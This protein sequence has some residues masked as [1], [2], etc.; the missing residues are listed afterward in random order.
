[1]NTTHLKYAIEVEKTRSITQA[2]DNLYMAQPNLSKAIR[3]LEESIGFS[4]FN[5]TSRGVFPTEKGAKFLAYAKNVL[6]QLDKIEALA[7]PVNSKIQKFSL[8]IPRGSYIADGFAKFIANLEDDKGIHVNIYET[9]SMQT[10]S[11]VTD[12]TSM[13]GIVRYNTSYENYYLDYLHDKQLAHE[14][15]WIFEELVLMSEHH[16][17][18]G[19]PRIKRQDLTPYIEIVHGDTA[20]PYL[21]GRLPKQPENVQEKKIYV[22]ER[23]SQFDLLSSV[24]K[25]YMWV[26][27]IP[28]DLRQRHA[29]VQRKCVDSTHQYKDTLIYKKGYTLSALDHHFIND[30]L[31]SR[32]EVASVKYD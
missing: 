15:I 5:R 22:Y 19:Q 7:R 29:L 12:G 11:H 2:A 21:T 6:V 28:D 17:L 25:T 18:A 3:E 1:M 14:D 27:P 4:I 32:D 31:K 9:N 13:L 30:L 23:G 8:S 26:S 10:I 16:P 20:I 24:P